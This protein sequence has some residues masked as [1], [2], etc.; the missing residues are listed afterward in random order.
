MLQPTSPDNLQSW[1]KFVAAYY[2]PIRAGLGL[3]PFVGEERADKLAQ[4]FF[5]KMYE[6]DVL[7]RRPEITGRFRNW[8]YV[9]ARRHAID[10]W[11]KNRRRLERPEALAALEP[12]DPHLAG[13]EET[14]FDADESYAL[15]V[16][17]MTISR[18]RKHLLEAGKSE[19]WMIFEEL[20]LALIIPAACRKP[21]RSSWRCSPARSATSWT[22]A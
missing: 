7:R 19:H 21:A 10:E 1:D 3:T 15:S 17:H 18:V 2:E 20:V 4:S 9:A 12:A 22:T 16:L 13:P 11:R 8:L 5:V 14:R 6:R